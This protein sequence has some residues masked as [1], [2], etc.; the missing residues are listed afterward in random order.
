MGSMAAIDLPFVTAVS[1]VQA[2]AALLPRPALMS[3][4]QHSLTHGLL[5][6]AAATIDGHPARIPGRQRSASALLKIWPAHSA[7]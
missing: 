2:F 3:S 5:A 4:G 1:Y 7:R 6:I